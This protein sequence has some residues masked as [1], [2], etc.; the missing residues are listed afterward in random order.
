MMNWDNLTHEQFMRL[1]E[2]RSLKSDI[3]PI[4]KAYQINRGY[5][6]EVALVTTLEHLDMNG[7]FFDLTA[8][9]WNE[10]EHQLEDACN[11]EEGNS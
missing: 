7:Q 5:S 6:A 3:V 9:E 4:A 11:E 10:F 8:D 1:C 2:C